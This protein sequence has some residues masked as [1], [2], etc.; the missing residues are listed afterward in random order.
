MASELVV[1]EDDRERLRE[2]ARLIEVAS[3]RDDAQRDARFLHRFA[4]RLPSDL[5]S[6]GERERLKTAFRNAAAADD[7]S[8]LMI[9]AAEEWLDAAL[10]DAGAST[11]E[12][13]ER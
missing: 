10:S 12:E 5:V 7:A 6:L 11:D 3:L 4:E 13:D 8:P 1:T 2:I 9:L